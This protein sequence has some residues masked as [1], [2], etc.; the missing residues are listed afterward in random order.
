[1]KRGSGLQEKYDCCLWKFWS[2]LLDCHVIFFLKQLQVMEGM[3][4]DIFRALSGPS[5]DVRKKVA[6]SAVCR[7]QRF[8][9]WTLGVK[10]RFFIDW[11]RNSEPWFAFSSFTLFSLRCLGFVMNVT[12]L[13]LLFCRSSTSNPW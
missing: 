1:M 7:P 5:L 8:C 12:R 4:M 13:C 2:S 3:V 11:S 9:R 10:V 6:N